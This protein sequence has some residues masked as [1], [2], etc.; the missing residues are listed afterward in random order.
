MKR[1]Y[2]ITLLGSLV[3][4]FAL[5]FIFTAQMSW[6]TV[7]DCSDTSVP[8]PQTVRTVDCAGMTY[9]FPV[10]FIESEPGLSLS[11]TGGN[12]LQ[13]SVSASATTDLDIFKMLTNI[14]FW[15]A[16]S[17]AIAFAIMYKMAQKKKQP[18]TPV[19]PKEEK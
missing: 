7:G 14:V 2:I 13:T 18:T 5:T 3:A 6:K 8:L 9:G 16:F 1:R 11:L 15:T 17:A 4:G 10:R 19:E 12:G